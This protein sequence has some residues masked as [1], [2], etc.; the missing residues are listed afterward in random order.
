MEEKFEILGQLIDSLESLACGLVLPLGADF[1]INQL[2]K[3]LPEK[4][5]EF[6]KVF[7]ELSGENPWD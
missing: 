5:E 1:H 4:V 7:V 3:I 6:K 2:K